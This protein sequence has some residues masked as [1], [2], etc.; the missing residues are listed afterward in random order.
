M[1]SKYES[2]IRPGGRIVMFGA[3]SGDDLHLPIR[4]I[5]FP[6]ISLIGTSMG[7]REEFVQMLEWV[8]K[9][10]IHPVVD[11]IYSLQNTSQAFERIEKGEQFGNIAIQ[12]D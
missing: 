12:I 1:F 9:Y 6:Q 8:E 3:S 5:F 4:S 7:D 10:Q 2:V 11:S